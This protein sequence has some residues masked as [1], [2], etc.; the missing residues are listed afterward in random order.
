MQLAKTTRPGQFFHSL[1][2]VRICAV[3]LVLLQHESLLARNYLGFDFAFGIFSR[4]QF[5][6]DLFFLLS[7]F[8]ATWL[9]GRGQQSQNPGIHF[10]G[11][12]LRRLLPLLWVLTTA[13]LML[14]VMAGSA[15]RHEGWGWFQILR[16]YTMLP[17]PGYP[18]ILPAWT[19]SFEL[20]FSTAWTVLLCVSQRVKLT[21]L[22]LWALAIGVHGFT[23]HEKPSS[24]LPGFLLHP[25]FLDFI[26]GAFLA[27]WVARTT[28]RAQS[29]LM[30][31]ALGCLSLALCLALEMEMK[32]CS[33]LVRRI[34]WGSSSALV[35]AGLAMWERVGGKFNTLGRFRLL[36]Q[37]SYSI[38]LTHSLLLVALL[39]RFKSLLQHP[40]AAHAVLIGLAGGICLIG[41]GVHL[42]V[43]RPLLKWFRNSG[44]VPRTNE[45]QNSR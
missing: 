28:L 25:Y 5:R 18:L 45:S 15:G 3:V 4:G 40:I 39:P 37:S 6:I 12:R 24:W 21:T 30:L 22:L 11:N 44:P 29:A 35:I 20:I 43:E 19:L 17:A 38:Y 2:A 1:E 36:A 10:L 31:I 33:E 34:A 7:G 32:H 9:G 16:S 42:W 14:I 27:E 23:W 41:V 13:K 8:F 26:G